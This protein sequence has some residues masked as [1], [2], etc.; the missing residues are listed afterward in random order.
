M[1]LG[2]WELASWDTVFIES[3]LFALAGFAPGSILFWVASHLKSKG[4][5]NP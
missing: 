4:E 2:Q 1:R 5:G 3:A